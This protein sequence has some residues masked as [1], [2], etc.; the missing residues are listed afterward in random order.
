MRSPLVVL[1]LLGIAACV[2]PGTYTV[3]PATRP[4]PAP[5]PAPVQSLRPL[6]ITIVRPEAGKLLVQTNRAAYVAVFEIVPER[7]VALI[8]PTTARQQSSRVAGL[9]WLSTKFIRPSCGKPF[10]LAS[11]T[12]TGFATSRELGRLPLRAM[13]P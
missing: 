10:S 5:A 8:Y 4:T 12:N 2:G 7:G 13:A 1:A 11:P 3:V 9:S 6:E